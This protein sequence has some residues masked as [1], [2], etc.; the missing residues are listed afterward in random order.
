MGVPVSAVAEEKRAPLRAWV[1]FIG[2]TLPL[3]DRLS[4][5]LYGVLMVSSISGLVEY[6]GPRDES[7]LQYMLIVLFITVILWGLLDGI[8]YALMSAANRAER[9]T[10]LE[11]L[12]AEPDKEKRIELIREDVEG[13]MPYGLDEEDKRR[14]FEIVDRGATKPREKMGLNRLNQHEKRII[15]AAFL[16][17]FIPLVWLVIPYLFAPSVVTGALISHTIGFFM[18]V[19]IGYFYAKSAHM[20]PWIGA[21][22]CGAIGLA[23]IWFADVSNMVVI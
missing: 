11:T 16:L 21:L 5:M 18:F 22:I 3:G 23:V 19:S 8:S 17:D 9:E 1:P 10:L 2:A 7:G 4:E 20:K 6:V 15:L 13:T 14:I 12:A